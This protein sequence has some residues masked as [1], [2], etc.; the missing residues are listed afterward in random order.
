[1]GTELTTQDIKALKEIANIIKIERIDG[2]TH[3]SFK[4]DVVLSSDKNMVLVSN[5][6]IVL[7]SR[8]LIHLNPL[9]HRSENIQK[10]LK[11]NEDE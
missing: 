1:M 3:V 11:G 8:D 4:D 9:T 6:D 7:K 2:I 5:R 10:L